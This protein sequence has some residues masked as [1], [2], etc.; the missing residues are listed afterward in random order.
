VLLTATIGEVGSEIVFGGVARNLAA[1]EFFTQLETVQPGQRRGL[2]VSQRLAGVERTGQFDKDLAR[3]LR[4]RDLK[5][6]GQQ[7]FR[8]VNGHAHARSLPAFRASSRRIS[9]GLKSAYGGIETEK[10]A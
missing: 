5:D 1:G 10:D 3:D 6:A 7:P 2:G 9:G 4:F 8:Q